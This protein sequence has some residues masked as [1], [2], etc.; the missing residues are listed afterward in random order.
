MENTYEPPTLAL[1]GDYT[2]QTLGAGGFQP[3]GTALLRVW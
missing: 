2:A 1:V 3:E